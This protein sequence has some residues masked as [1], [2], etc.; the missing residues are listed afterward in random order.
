MGREKGEPE[1][2][3]EGEEETRRLYGES[4]SLLPFVP[5]LRKKICRRIMCITN[6]DELGGY[7]NKFIY[8]LQKNSISYGEGQL[9]S[10][11]PLRAERQF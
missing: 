10:P 11:N 1:P 6:L 7:G 9:F 4:H 5:E 3:E 8:S 2:L